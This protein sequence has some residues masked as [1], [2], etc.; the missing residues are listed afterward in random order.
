MGGPFHELLVD[1]I[2][3]TTMDVCRTMLDCHVEA[4]TPR[5]EEGETG[6]TNGVAAMIGLAGKYSGNGIVVCSP[7][8]ACTL[9]GRL[10]TTRFENVNEEV[11]DALGE[12][13]NMIVGNIKTNLWSRLGEMGLSTPTIIHGR[14]FTTHTTG[15]HPWTVVPFHLE[16]QIFHVQM[17][18]TATPLLPASI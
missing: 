6:S 9:A 12:I 5:W 7:E 3:K 2:L 16:G 15:K 17:I 11:L 10:L 1:E 14:D 8:A 13:A 18:L 4:G